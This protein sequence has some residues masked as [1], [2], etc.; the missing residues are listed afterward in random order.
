M[1]TYTASDAED[2]ALTIQGGDISFTAGSNDDGY[3]TFDGENIVLTQVGVDA[4]EA[5]VDLPAVILTATD[6]SG[7]TSTDG[8]TPFVIRPIIVDSVDPA[9]NQS[10]DVI[11]EGEQAVFTVTL[12]GT[13]TEA[14]TYTIKL[15]AGTDSANGDDY[16]IDL[17]NAVFS[18]ANITYNAADG[19]ITVPAR[20]DSFT[21]TVATTD[22]TEIE[23][24]ENFTL[25]VGGRTG[26]AVV[27]D[28]DAA[29]DSVVPVTDPAGTAITEGENA[30]FQV[31]L[32]KP[33]PGETR[34]SADLGASSDSADGN[35]Y[36][37]DLAD[38]TFSNNVTYDASTNEFVV[39]QGVADFT[40]TI[41]TNDDTEV[42]SQE[43][44]TLTVG[45]QSGVTAIADNDSGV[46]SV[47][48]VTQ[49]AGSAI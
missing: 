35:D 16:D 29:V 10:G 26:T 48:P 34:Y 42:E 21:V 41:E 1:A 31:T 46:T 5:G 39:P 3:Y 49:P 8:E 33:T 45:G 12:S 40:V 9:L 32:T 47:T 6:S 14:Q 19:T 13:T 28:N 38:A 27:A 15:G 24:S 18:N 25:E 37:T 23:S 30:V 36:S 7:L 17:S 11:V 44:F 22:D 43:N 4:I 20:V 2:G